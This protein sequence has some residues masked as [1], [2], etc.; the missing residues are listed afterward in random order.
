MEAKIS[1]SRID[2]LGAALPR[3]KW[4]PLLDELKAEHIPSLTPTG[5]RLSVVVGPSSRIDAFI[6]RTTTMPDEE[7]LRILG[8]YGIALTVAP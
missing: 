7:V 6:F 4:E 5:K 1:R 3:E 2:I 8:K